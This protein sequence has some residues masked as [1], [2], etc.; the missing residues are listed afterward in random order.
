MSG[1]EHLIP[2]VQRNVSL[3]PYTTFRIGGPADYFVIG[4]TEEKICGALRGARETN[5]PV[6]V[7]AGGSNV[8]FPDE[9]FR[10]IV[11][12]IHTTDYDI[13]G[14]TVRASAG[15]LM[16]ELVKA[17]TERGLGGL[18]WA[19]GLPGT[20]GGAV[21]GNAGA[22]GGE[23]KD[24]VTEARYVTQEGEIRAAG[25]RECEFAYRSSFF[26][27]HNAI[28]LSTTLRLAKGDPVLL[29]SVAQSHIAYRESRHPLDLP[30]AGS[31]FKNVSF[32]SI[33]D[34]LKESV[35]SVLKEDPFP[36][37]PTAYLV[38]RAGLAGRRVGGA[39]ISE[40]HTNFI[41]NKKNAGAKDVLSLISIAKKAVKEKFCVDLEVEIQC[42]A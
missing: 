10:G 32:S 35:R 7:L 28:V 8:L 9:G 6:F 22:F 41:V 13:A 31:I 5:T 33:P 21:R 42:I 29:Q 24:N 26:K 36:V 11:I 27:T 30:N 20:L 25:R 12:C 1:I 14:E 37:I 3:A 16:A 4:D 19:G 38:S 17:T 15:V 39:E 23:M 34:D 40:K 18:E 2:G